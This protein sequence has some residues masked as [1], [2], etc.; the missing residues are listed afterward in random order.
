MYAVLH[1]MIV[2]EDCTHK[3]KED[4]SVE[5]KLLSFLVVCSSSL[6]HCRGGLSICIPP[7]HDC[8]GGLS[9]CSPPLH[10]CR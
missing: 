2:G 4:E 8:M 7:L 1:C 6:A 3:N 5:N 9:V 10:D